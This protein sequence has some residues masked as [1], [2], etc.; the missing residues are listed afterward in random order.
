MVGNTV[1]IKLSQGRS[2]LLPKGEGDSPSLCK[3]TFSQRVGP[4]S[5]NLDS[6]VTRQVVIHFSA[7][8]SKKVWRGWPLGRPLG[9]NLNLLK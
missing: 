9:T 3:W 4:K 5:K 1:L 8:C 6:Y 2:Q 7:F